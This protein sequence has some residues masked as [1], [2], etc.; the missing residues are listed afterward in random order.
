[1]KKTLLAIALAVPVL[2]LAQA[3]A[4][5][6]PDHIDHLHRAI[7]ERLSSPVQ[8][9]ASIKVPEPRAAIR[10]M[11]TAPIM[12]APGS[13]NDFAAAPVRNE[14]HTQIPVRV[15]AQLRSQSGVFETPLG[16]CSFRFAVGNGR[17]S[18]PLN[19]HCERG[20]KGSGG[21][22]LDPDGKIHVHAKTE[23]GHEYNF[24]L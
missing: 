11:A 20:G 16:N 7:M 18:G 9:P 3:P 1:M 24:T 19:V 8:I 6:P 4:V 10:A 13:E 14:H 21:W 12:R 23:D 15:H 22:V 17:I 2:A 5:A